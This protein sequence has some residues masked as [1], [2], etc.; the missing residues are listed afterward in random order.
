[1]NHKEIKLRKNILNAVLKYRKE[2]IGLKSDMKHFYI[3][4]DKKKMYISNLPYR[5]FWEK[6]WGVR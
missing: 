6:L 1:M 2:M 4:L 5:T 3:N